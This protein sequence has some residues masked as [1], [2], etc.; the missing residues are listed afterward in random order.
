MK[1]RSGFSLMELLMVIAIIG[2]LA[3]LLLSALAAAKNRAR[4]A[5]CTN[6]LQQIALGVRMYADDS[7]DKAPK[8][9]ARTSH[10]Y[11]AYK[12]LMK[13]Y[14]GLR[15]KS[16]V[17]DRLFACPADTFYFDYEIG[18]SRGPRVGY[19][20]GSLCALPSQD[21]SSYVFNAG[22]LFSYPKSGTN[23]TRPGI[24]GV[25]LEA[26]KHPDRT[27]LVFETPAVCPFSWHQPKRPL[28]LLSTKYCPNL[29]FNDA[30]NMVSFVDGHV[31]FVKIYWDVQP[32]LN[33]AADYD[34]PAGYDYQWSP[35]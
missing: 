27:A 13:N 2:I 12:E 14:V 18:T 7:S 11:N 8:P 6:N 30:V 23:F 32:P 17:Q 19:V 21:F 5:V 35:N 29:R 34:P 10:P 3:A 24:A 20:A 15:G 16:S 1:S 9:A 26:V 33:C 28:Y 31:S 25:S 4:R 22:N